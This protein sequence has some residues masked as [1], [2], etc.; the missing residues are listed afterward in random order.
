MTEKSCFHL[1]EAKPNNVIHNDRTISPSYLLKEK[2]LGVEV[3]RNAEE[4]QKLYEAF[5]DEACTN[6]AR[7]TKQKVQAKRLQWSGVAL[8][9]ESTTMDDLER[10]VE[11][12]NKKFGWQCYQI[13]IHRDE[14]HI[15]KLTNKTVYNLHAHLEFFMLNKQGVY[16][17][18]K[19][20]FGKKA[21]S[22]IQTLV[23]KELGMKRGEDARITK[24]KHLDHYQQR[25]QSK[26]LEKK[27]IEQ[28]ELKSELA[29]VQQE[30]LELANNNSALNQA[31][32]AIKK[33][34]LIFQG[35]TKD[36]KL[37]NKVLLE[38]VS[39]ILQRYQQAKVDRDNYKKL[40]DTANSEK[41]KLNKQHQD[42]SKRVNDFLAQ[43]ALKLELQ[44]C[45]STA[46]LKQLDTKLTELS[47][48]NLNYRRTKKELEK[49]IADITKELYSKADYQAVVN[50]NL[51]LKQD[52]QK[53][54]NQIAALTAQIPT[55]E[56][57]Q[58]LIN[59][60]IQAKL[61]AKEL[62]S[63]ADYQAV[64]NDNSKLKQNNLN[65]EGKL[66]ELKNQKPTIVEKEHVLTQAEIKQNV[67]SARQQLIKEGWH[68]REDYNKLSAFR[69]EALTR[70]TKKSDVAPITDS[71]FFTR[72]DKLMLD[73]SQKPKVITEKQ[74]LSDN[75]IE[76]LPKVQSLKK[77]ISQLYTKDQ[78]EAFIQKATS[79]SVA[80][81]K[82]DDLV[83]KYNSLLDNYEQEQ[84]DNDELCFNVIDLLKA[85]TGENIDDNISNEKLNQLVS[86]TI[87]DLI[88][89][90]EQGK[91][92]LFV[93]SSSRHIR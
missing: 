41:E 25:Q 76:L 52:N 31:L 32:D 15:D 57:K 24:N 12:F 43:C 78:V 7:R 87:E 86:N 61:N 49:S 77:Q 59:Q 35:D 20:D 3:N 80:L 1:E 13:A 47:D 68:S 37:T 19:R 33:Q 27:E 48:R 40:L 10:L 26:L 65:L 84:R 91:E 5:Y 38:R 62:Y 79:N 34:F 93:K 88:E 70:L 4:A 17:F 8:I 23:A 46:I 2:S 69:K 90:E 66:T 53:L 89:M 85:V 42:Y 71:E 67:E 28:Q 63:K 29:K 54:N 75:E 39:L 45:D 81:D 73:L 44:N 72:L 83:N 55:A 36:T 56:Q 92:N 18:K 9:N 21:M 11:I 51:K 6:Y 50:D 30:K 22:Q 14:G 60:G 16:C 58:E 64:I 74:E 82:Y